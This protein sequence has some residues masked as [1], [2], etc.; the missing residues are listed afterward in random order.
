MR[1]ARV[2]RLRVTA[3][4]QQ[5]STTC[6]HPRMIGAVW[7]MTGTAVLCDGRMLP[8]IGTTLFSVT[9]VAGLIQRLPKQLRL[10]RSAMRA[11]TAAAVHLAF[12]ERM[13][14]RLQGLA[15]L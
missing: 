2:S 7:C 4:A 8:D 13:R 12:E 5:R 14:E 15:A 11:V 6:Q 3:L 9:L 1:N 10:G